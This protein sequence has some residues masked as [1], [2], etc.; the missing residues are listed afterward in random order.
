MTER[1]YPQLSLTRDTYEDLEELK[2]EFGKN[3]FN[4]VLRELID[5]YKKQRS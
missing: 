3:S 2:V 5:E 1:K 4:K